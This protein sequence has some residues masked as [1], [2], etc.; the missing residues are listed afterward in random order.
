MVKESMGKGQLSSPLIVADKPCEHGSSGG[1]GGGEEEMGVSSATSVLVLSTLIA[2]CGSYVFGTAV[3]SGCI[4]STSLY[5]IYYDL[6]LKKSIIDQM[7]VFW[8][9]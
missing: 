1:G 7:F 8:N 2:V 3:I 4:Y 6:Q 5:L 9:H